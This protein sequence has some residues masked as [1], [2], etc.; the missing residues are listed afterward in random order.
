MTDNNDPDDTVMASVLPG[1]RPMSFVAEA[2]LTVI[3]LAGYNNTTTV[4]FAVATTKG[5]S[6]T[7]HGAGAATLA[8]SKIVSAVQTHDADTA[9]SK[10]ADDNGSGVRD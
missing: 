9:A 4:A 8:V 6:A 10:A 1:D 5:T 7:T 2:P 3:A